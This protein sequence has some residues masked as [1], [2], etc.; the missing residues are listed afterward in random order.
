M[1]KNFDKWNN[2]KRETNQKEK[3]LY[4][5]PRQ[6]WFIRLG[7]NVGFEQDGKGNE[8]LRPVIVLKKFN[9]RVFWAVPLTTNLKQ[10]N[11]YFP[12]NN[13]GGKRAMAILSQIRLIDAKRLKYK[14]GDIEKNVFAELKKA[15][16]EI[17][18]SNDDF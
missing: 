4:F 18:L 17:L 1:Y 6:I 14:I 9:R 16:A 8:Y 12:V 3:I 10:G 15:I 5:H 11:L 13:S 7:Q 2:L